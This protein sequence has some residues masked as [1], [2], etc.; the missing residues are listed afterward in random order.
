MDDK[1]KKLNRVY[2]EWKIINL[3]FIRSTWN[4][5]GMKNEHKG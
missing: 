2:K 5:F 1:P 4:T 3:L